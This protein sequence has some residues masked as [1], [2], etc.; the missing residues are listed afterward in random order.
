MSDVPIETIELYGD[1]VCL[2]NLILI[3][4][5]QVELLAD[6]MQTV[7][8][9]V[10]CDPSANLRHIFIAPT[11]DMSAIV[12]S[13]IQRLFDG[14][15]GHEPVGQVARSVSLPVD[16]DGKLTTFVIVSE[17]MVRGLTPDKI[18]SLDVVANIL[19]TLLHASTYATI[20]VLC[21][22]RECVTEVPFLD[23]LDALG[24]PADVPEPT[25]RDSQIEP[26]SVRELAA[27][28]LE[29]YLVHRR[30]MAILSINS[31]VL[32]DGEEHLKAITPRLPPDL[33]MRLEQSADE[34][35]S[36][37]CSA[38]M[39]RVEPVE[40]WRRIRQ[41]L[42]RTVFDLLA[43]HSAYAHHSPGDS[44]LFAIGRS[45]FYA[46]TL[47]PFWT[48]ACAELA[49]A[50]DKQDEE[51]AASLDTLVVLTSMFLRRLGVTVN[52]PEHITFD[53]RWTSS[54]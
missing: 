47:A 32:L 29:D 54:S 41:C 50:H 5:E 37:I 12:D 19:E 51:L 38:C 2:H 3:E 45:Q 46:T 28:A 23:G 18:Y 9:L 17:S 26:G 31:L 42:M 30:K 52:D 43:R 8:D 4:N 44:Q 33:P 24:C 10:E 16:H 48:R 7:L 6:V 15:T 39:H 13:A 27:G 20:R 14:P 11:I 22:A 36:A 34:L 35:R 25:I 1:A 53:V 40:S 49:L 21:A